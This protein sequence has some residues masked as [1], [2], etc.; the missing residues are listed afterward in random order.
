M[1]KAPLG[2]GA[3]G[4]GLGGEGW[5]LAIGGL[6]AVGGLV[7][8]GPDPLGQFE[9]EAFLF[10]GERGDDVDGDGDGV[11]IDGVHFPE[12]LSLSVSDGTK[13]TPMVPA[14][15]RESRQSQPPAWAPRP[16]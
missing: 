6:V 8:D 11:V 3:L 4:G 13:P 14:G 15:P 7:Y 5:G 12:V 10:L 2:G 9:E 1:G 16:Q